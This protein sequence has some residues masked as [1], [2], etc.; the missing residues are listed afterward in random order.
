MH[1]VHLIEK[2]ILAAKRDVAVPKSYR[3]AKLIQIIKHYT[4]N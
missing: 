4:Y 1:L 3:P 2:K